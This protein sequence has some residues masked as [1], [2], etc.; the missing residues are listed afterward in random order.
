MSDLFLN[1]LNMSIA[2]SWLI[3]A[4][5]LLRFLLKKAPKW[6]AV[7]LWGIVALRLVVPF[8]FESALSLIPSAETFNAHNIQYET[9]AISSGIPAVNNAVNP[10]LG[11]TFAP[12]SVGSIN[13]L[14]IWTLVVS[15]I[16]LVGIA[17]MLLYAVISYVRVR[18]SVAE[19]VPYEGNIFLCDYVK[20]PFILGLVRPKIYLPSSMDEAAMGPVI[21]HEKAHLAR[22]DHW[23][24]PLGFLILTV[25]WFNPLCWVTYVL[26]CRDIELA[27]DEKVI[28]QMDLDGKKQYSTALLECNTGRRLVTICPLAFGEVGV[29]ERVKNVL[30]YKKPAFWLIAV[31]VV[32]C[33]VVTAC[34]ATNPVTEEPSTPNAERPTLIVDGNVYVNPYMP[35]S[36]LPYGYQSA[37]KLTREQANNTGLEGIEYF[38]HPSE[39][40]DF[41]TYQECGTPIDLNTV[42]SEQRQ[43]AYMRWIQV[44]DDGVEGRKL[45]LD[46]VVMLSQKGDALSWSDF[47]RYQGW[48]IGSGLYIMRYEIDELFDVLVGGV[49]D[50]TPMYIALRVHNEADDSI[51]I[52]TE[53]VSTFVEA[54]RNDVPKVIGLKPDGGGEP[55]PEEPNFSTLSEEQAVIHQ[56][57][58]ERNRSADPTGFVSCASFAEIACIVADGSDFSE[59]I[60]YGWALYEE[61]RVTDNGLKT[62]RGSHVPVAITF[63]EDPSGTLTLEEYW[64][65]RDGSYYA[66]D[67]REKFPAHI[68][69]D[70]MDSQKFIL[71]Q[72]QECYAQAVAATGLDTDQVIGSLIETICSGPALSSNPGDYIEAHPIEY[73]ELTYYGRYT[74]K[75]CFTKFLK[76][77]Q[78][79]LRGHIMRA[80]MDDIAPEAQLKL[81]AET[82]QEY[83]DAWKDAAKSV[84]KQH[85]MEWI[86]ENQPAIYLLLQMI[87]E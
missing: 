22:R 23:W 59:Y 35:V 74:L 14:Y 10:V 51:D 15:A 16:W 57:I 40:E 6:I 29:K 11:E 78:T 83:F 46:D 75:Y 36:Y 26:L 60:H 13:P 64:Q 34:F 39:T 9:P 30:N 45:T 5:V 62:V 48:E 38:V 47:E 28:R 80:A 68:V 77:G 87:S 42:D 2:A 61:Y 1:I 43:W 25:H 50:E 21:A 7:L 71:Q 66:Q 32:A 8:S 53:D 44:K 82:G 20:S 33:G 67:I 63:R 3:L 17:A 81:Y 73:R 19:R 56:A 86:E 69:E 76:G 4:V 41:Y 54:H 84:G 72:T 65:P 55:A 79:D 24:K 70:G 52:R 37:G 49:P 31:A 85:D 18:Q 12:N 58:L 27:C